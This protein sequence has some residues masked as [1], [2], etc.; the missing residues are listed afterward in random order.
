[1]VIRYG[2]LYEVGRSMGFFKADDGLIG[3]RY[4]ERLKG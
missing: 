1:M 2:L 3:L 4:P